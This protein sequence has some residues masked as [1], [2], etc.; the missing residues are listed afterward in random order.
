MARKSEDFKLNGK[1]IHFECCRNKKAASSSNTSNS[2][3]EY[4]YIKE[5]EYDEH[6]DDG[7]QEVINIKFSK[8]RVSKIK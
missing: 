5:I 2:W 8:K 7:I 6:G 4:R 1:F 3:Q